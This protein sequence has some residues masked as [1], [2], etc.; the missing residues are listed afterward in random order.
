MHAAGVSRVDTAFEEES[1][2]LVKGKQEQQQGDSAA[3]Y[4]EPGARPSHHACGAQ[5]PS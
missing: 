1:L 2:G 5:N 3:A 4:Y